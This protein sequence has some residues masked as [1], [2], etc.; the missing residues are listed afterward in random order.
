V[1]PVVATQGTVVWEVLD[2]AQFPLVFTYEVRKGEEILA[3]NEIYIDLPLASTDTTKLSKVNSRD[4]KVKVSVPGNANRN[5]LLMDI[6]YPSP[7]ALN[8][9]SLSWNPVEII[10]VDSQTQKNVTQFNQ[11]I[12]IQIQ[13]DENNIF[14]ADEKSLSIFYYDPVLVDWFPLE[15]TVDTATNTL[16][17]QSDH[18][19]VFDYKANNWQSYMVPSVDAFKTSDFTGA[20]TYQINLWTPPAPGGLQP[21]V[22]LSYNSQV[23]D[24]STT[25][26]QA[27]WVGMGWD[28]DTGLV[29]R[30]LH[31]TDSDWS[32]DTF[33]ISVAGMSGLLLPIS[34]TGDITQ[35]NTA[36]NA[37]MKVE[38][39]DATYRFTAWTKDGTKYEFADTTD[40]NYNQA[41][42]TS[43][44]HTW[45]WGLTSV[46]DVHGNTINYTYQAE[47]KPGCANEIA[48][49]P[50]FITYGNGKYRIRFVREARTDYQT[51]WTTT[52][53]RALYGTSR[54]KE[55]Y[56][57]HNTGSWVTIKRYVLSYAP[58]NTT[59]IYPNFTFSAGGKSLTLVGVQEFDSS[60]NALP[61]VTFT[62]ADGMHL[63][64]VNNGQGGAV[65]IN[66][67]AWAY[68]D[69]VNLDIRSFKTVF[70]T[71]PNPYGCYDVASG[72]L[73]S[74]W[75]YG[76]GIAS[77]DGTKYLRLGKSSE[78]GVVRLV[79][80]EAL[81]KPSNEYRFAVNARRITAGCLT[82]AQALQ[83]GFNGGAIATA[84]VCDTTTTDQVAYL[85]SSAGLLSTSQ[86]RLACFGCFIRSFEFNIQPTFYRVTSRTVTTQPNNLTSTY[87]YQYDN[88]S[89]A[90]EALSY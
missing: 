4:G 15:T 36:D 66:Y 90:G 24:E 14:G 87:T 77:C 74:G 42:A 39:N 76:G 80:P 41:C 61:A 54:L 68:R 70:Q 75:I 58:N 79:I 21:S 52:S 82:T 56:I 23:V 6:R 3:T 72:V 1:I 16:T 25:L 46:T 37:F 69:D 78:I 5:P 26:T 84:I 67:Q 19:T 48:V 62:Y 43:N 59:N 53:A 71:T 27:S 73:P 81:I 35:Y 9:Y 40:N 55:V 12:T 29:T 51:S 30:N 17:A 89:P 2:Y 83:Y 86:L 33:N 11:P 22:V 65:A 60:G 38:S 44:N 20:G 13:Y 34:K 7:H 45:R 18:L 8:A 47:T 32:D 31:G 88:A 10:A 57:E 50:T 64:Q 63:T 49:Y 28:L 85:T